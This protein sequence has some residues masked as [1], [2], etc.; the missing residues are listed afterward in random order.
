VLHLRVR[1]RAREGGRLSAR[2]CRPC[3][4]V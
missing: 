2:A 1:A 3:E 4:H